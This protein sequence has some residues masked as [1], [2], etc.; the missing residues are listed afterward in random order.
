MPSS[1]RG[2]RIHGNDRAGGVRGAIVGRVASP[3]CYGGN[4]G[5]KPDPCYYVQDGER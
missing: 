2:W 1:L 4:T 3:L 5:S